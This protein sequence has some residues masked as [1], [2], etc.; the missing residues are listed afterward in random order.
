M[1]FIGELNGETVIPEDV[2]DGVRVRCPECG[3]EM[4]PR[5]RTGSDRTRHFRHTGSNVD[6]CGSGESKKHQK[7][8]AAA[9]AALRQEFSEHYRSDLEVNLDVSGTATLSD[10]RV[11]DVFLEFESPNV[12]YGD[13]I[14]IEIQYRNHG[15]D[16][17]ATTHDYLSLGYSVY[18]ANVNDFEKGELDFS[19]VTADF[20]AQENHAYATY[21]YDADE[22]STELAASLRWED[23]KPSCNH[24]WQEADVDESA[25]EYDSC[26]QCGTNRL[27]D[28]RR[29]R[30]LYDDSEM[31]G[32]VV[33]VDRSTVSQGGHSGCRNGGGHEWEP[34]DFGSNDVYRCIY[35]MARKVEGVYGQ[36]HVAKEY[37][38]P[39][40]EAG[41][42]L[43]EVTSNPANCEHDWQHRGDDYKCRNCGMIDYMPY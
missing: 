6:G 38:V 25:V 24:D 15:K 34:A 28:E 11:A 14:V 32:P 36:W 37:V 7:M 33:G 22:F 10:R 4:T 5:G 12:F 16:L 40:E 2:E 21:H 43:T 13:G 29:A 42:D 30:Y 18:W 8:K 27:Y 9:Y 23:P 20:N 41:S 19:T 3:G 1:P 26:P 17:F 31:V 39:I 35:C